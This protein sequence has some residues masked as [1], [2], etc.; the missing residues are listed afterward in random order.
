MYDRGPIQSAFN[1]EVIQREAAVFV[2]VHGELDVATAPLLGE[3]LAEAQETGTSV[4]VVDIDDVPFVDS[5]GLRA[6]LQA[7]ASAGDR[8]RITRGC[9]QAQRLFELAGVRETLPFVGRGDV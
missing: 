9:E 3:R 5:T 1:I 7:Q 6:L 4:I 2:E 8:L